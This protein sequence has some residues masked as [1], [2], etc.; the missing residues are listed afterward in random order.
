M[1]LPPVGYRA[2]LMP[3]FDLRS[4]VKFEVAPLS[5]T[6]IFFCV[7]DGNEILVLMPGVLYEFHTVKRTWIAHNAQ[8]TQEVAAK[9]PFITLREGDIEGG[10][11]Q[12]LRGHTYHPKAIEDVIISQITKIAAALQEIQEVISDWADEG[13]SGD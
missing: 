4:N 5:Q 6:P 11:F 1:Y 7:N 2:P 9:A 8:I 3:K 13:G 12:A 10:F